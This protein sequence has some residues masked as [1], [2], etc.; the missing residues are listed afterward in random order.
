[1]EKNLL[2]HSL[3]IL[4]KFQVVNRNSIRYVARQHCSKEKSCRFLFTCD[5][6]RK[7]LPQAQQK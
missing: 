4:I 2:N 7:M 5:D 6:K 1:M 3:M